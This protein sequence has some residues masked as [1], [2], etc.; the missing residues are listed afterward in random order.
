MSNARAETPVRSHRRDRWPLWK[1]WL[2]G[3]ALLIA[4]V[5]LSTLLMQAGYFIIPLLWAC[6]CGLGLGLL[7]M[8]VGTSLTMQIIGLCAG[9]VLGTGVTMAGQDEVRLF[10][11]TARDIA[12]ADAPG[13][14]AA[15]LHFRDARILF[16]EEGSAGVYGGSRGTGSN[17]KYNLHVAPVVGAGWT[18]GRPVAVFAVVGSPRFGHR[19]SDWRL[20]WNAGIRLTG[21]D[22][23]ERDAALDEIARRGRVSV[24]ANPLFIRW[25]A[26][27]E[28]EAA[29]ARWGLAGM[30]LIA[31]IGWS[32]L[33]AACRLWPKSRARAPGRT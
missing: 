4:D 13:T 21:A 11:G 24:V 18:P 31:M 2:G 15:F 10:G 9:I 3:I 30:L 29:A 17:L 27:P 33:L 1:I 32:L 14:G 20:P 26:D 23:A 8:A 6:L 22:A 12:I 25:S 5:L 7:A 28:A 16:D 19:V